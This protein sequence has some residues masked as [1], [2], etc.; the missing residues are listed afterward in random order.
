MKQEMVIEVHIEN[1]PGAQGIA[2]R[3]NVTRD[4]LLA[5]GELIAQLAND[6][7]RD[8]VCLVFHQ[9]GELSIS[10]RGEGIEYGRA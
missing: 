1:V 3:S 8:G 9:N 4:Q 2:V 6:P 7:T 10:S 5:M